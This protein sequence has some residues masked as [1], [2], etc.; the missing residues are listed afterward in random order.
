MHTDALNSST[1]PIILL[2]EDDP[3]QSD[4]LREILELEGYGVET[5]FSGDVALRKLSQRRYDLAILDIH[6][7]G[8]DGV[9]VLKWSR[10]HP[11]AK[12]VAVIMVSAFANQQEMQR[13]RA[14]G[15][16]ACFAKPYAMDDLLAVIAEVVKAKAV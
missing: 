15:A 4:M 7:P 5:A 10:E 16:A 14:E 1:K 6:M 13:Y 2:G 12:K 9:A 11:E 3:D 8:L